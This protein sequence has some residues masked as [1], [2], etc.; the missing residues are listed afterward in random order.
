MLSK[1]SQSQD[2]YCMLF[3]MRNPGLKQY[4]EGHR[5][6]YNVRVGS[7]SGGEREKKRVMEYM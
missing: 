6:R 4:S 2:K 1:I 7:E 5:E 3:I